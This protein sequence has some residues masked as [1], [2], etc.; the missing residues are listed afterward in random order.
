MKR[1]RISDILGNK[2][3]A[4]F[5]GSLYA[6]FREY[7]DNL[8]D[9]EHS[10]EEEVRFE[11]TY[12][13]NMDFEVP[14]QRFIDNRRNR[15]AVIL[16]LAGV[17]KS[18]TLRKFFGV[19]EA[20]S[21]ARF[22]SNTLVIPFYFD[23]TK[24]KGVSADP[25]IA[26]KDVICSGVLAAVEHVCRAKNVTIDDRQ[27]VSF[28][29]KHKPRLLTGLSIPRGANEQTK[30]EW[31]R[32]HAPYHAVA[33]ELKFVCHTSSIDRV[34]IVFD[35]LESCNYEEHRAIFLGALKL[36]ECMKSTGAIRRSY[37]VE[38][39]I[40]CRPATFNRLSRDS[41]IDGYHIKHRIQF[42]R[43]VDL[44]DIIKARLDYFV[45][46]IGQGAV[47]PTGEHP[48]RIS[49]LERWQ[50]SYAALK[51]IIDK[52][53]E[54]HGELFSQ[55]SNQNL[56]DAQDELLEVLQNSRWYEI[57]HHNEGQIEILKDNFRTTDAGIIRAL[58]LKFNNSFIPSINAPIGNLFYNHQSEE[59]D[60]ILIM[61]LR[62]LGEKS[63][64]G[65]YRFTRLTELR[66]ALVHCYDEYKIINSFDEIVSQLEWAGFARLEEAPSKVVDRLER[67]IIPQ[68]RGFELLDML[69]ESSVILE[70]FRDNTFINFEGSSKYDGKGTGTTL[71]E[72]NER[73]L[74]VGEFIEQIATAEK[75]LLGR[76]TQN[77][78]GDRFEELFGSL[79]ISHRC[80]IGF[81]KS[82]K[83][84]YYSHENRRSRVP[85]SVSRKA[86]DLRQFLRGA[87]LIKRLSPSGR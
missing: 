45:N 15:P 27:L 63:R 79:L 71:L 16:G 1:Q 58:G 53:S 64:N 60:L 38:L 22:D 18:T 73:F 68:T 67:L 31:L 30:I 2:T 75:R 80:L 85:S 35:D 55:L 83:R 4:K 61:C 36:R 40:S 25:E 74:R 59:L 6:Q 9:P 24:L 56:R 39:I 20:P 72:P 50:K 23:K 33:E 49:D 69:K 57:T 46:Q 44:A 11:H 8:L 26:V 7:F 19:L 65:K 37:K 86:K 42:E 77:I 47:S 41:K 66:D 51:E 70:I 62:F 21:I 12:V 5:S 10:S 29:Q 17:G 52:I 14:L 84:F 28:I 43:P 54:N 48:D 34:I 87:N 76:A 13:R 3:E 78:G 81:E 32:E 82:I